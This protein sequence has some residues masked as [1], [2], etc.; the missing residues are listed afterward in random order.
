MY[1]YADDSTKGDFT[2]L[3]AYFGRDSEMC[4]LHEKWAHLLGHYGIRSMHAS[5]FMTGQPQYRELTRDEDTKT[6]VLNEFCS[7]SKE[8]ADHALVVSTRLTTFRTAAN[9]ASIKPKYEKNVSRFLFYRMLIV[10]LRTLYPSGVGTDP[11]GIVVDDSEREA[12]N[13]YGIWRDAKRR[14]Q[15]AKDYLASITFADDR[16]VSPVQAA[17]LLAFGVREEYPTLDISAPIG[18]P[19]KNLFTKCRN[20]ENPWQWEHWDAD[21]FTANPD[22]IADYA[23]VG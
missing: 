18:G 16:Y 2:C 11:L 12:M 17:D 9:G 5:E 14:R 10:V 8:Y 20:R 1:L 4:L 6:R 22:I 7:I 21:R 15:V 3:A 19:F 13:F 23:L